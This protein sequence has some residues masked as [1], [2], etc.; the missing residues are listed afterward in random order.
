MK[1]FLD[2]V[3]EVRTLRAEVEEELMKVHSSFT[4]ASALMSPR[5]AGAGTALSQAE[6]GAGP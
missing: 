6:C 4:V 5:G 1:Q 3:R 2:M